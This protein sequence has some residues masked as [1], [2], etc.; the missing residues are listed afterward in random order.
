MIFSGG[1]NSSPFIDIYS[2][3]ASQSEVMAAYKAAYK[4]QEITD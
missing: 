3:C 1:L 4:C 2:G